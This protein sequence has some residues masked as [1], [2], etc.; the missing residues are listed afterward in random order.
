MFIKKFNQD[1]SE[2]MKQGQIRVKAAKTEGSDVS[3]SCEDNDGLKLNL[4]LVNFEVDSDFELDN[5]Q[6][7]KSSQLYDFE[8]GNA[9]LVDAGL[10]GYRKI[11]ANTIIYANYLVFAKDNKVLRLI[12]D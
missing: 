7:V 6:T 1:I 10:D 4:K 9:K 8:F 3:F 12:A 11:Y 2:K 5:H